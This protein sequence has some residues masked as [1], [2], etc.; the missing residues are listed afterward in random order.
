[1]NYI[2]SEEELTSAY[3][4]YYK[5]GRTFNIIKFLKSKT[6]VEAIASGKVDCLEPPYYVGYDIVNH[7][8]RN[9][10]GKKVKLWVEEG[11]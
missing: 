2:I 6:P 10:E 7:K 11:E 3:D 5:R 8:L 4:W 1:M 9:Y